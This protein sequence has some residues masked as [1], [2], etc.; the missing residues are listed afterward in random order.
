MASYKIAE[1]TWQDTEATLLNGTVYLKSVDCT[2]ELQRI[3]DGV[4]FSK[5]E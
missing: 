1:R 4:Q 3:Y 5:I 2:I